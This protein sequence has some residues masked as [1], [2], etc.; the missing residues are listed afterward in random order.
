MTEVLPPYLARRRSQMGQPSGGN[1]GAMLI[2]LIPLAV[3]CS[4]ANMPGE[5]P[6]PTALG[7]L[8]QAAPTMLL[9]CRRAMSPAAVQP[10]VLV[11]AGVQRMGYAAVVSAGGQVVELRIDGV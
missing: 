10:G 5:P 9:A 7:R 2:D 6:L 1:A 8:Q 3:N 4:M 11:P